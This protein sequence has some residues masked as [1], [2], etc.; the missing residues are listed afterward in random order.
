M[1]ECDTSQLEMS[2]GTTTDA[3][4][5]APAALTD[6]GGAPCEWLASSEQLRS[7]MARTRETSA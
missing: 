1:T 3:G 5:A 7:T 6:C 4:T 2:T